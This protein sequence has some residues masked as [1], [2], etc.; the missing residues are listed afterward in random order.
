MRKTPELVALRVTTE[1]KAKVVQL[2]E[3]LYDGNLSMAARHLLQRGLQEW[4]QE[5]LKQ[6]A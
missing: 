5:Q 6:A 3:R 2:A 4:E 1:Q